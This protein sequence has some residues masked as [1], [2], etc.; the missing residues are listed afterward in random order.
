MNNLILF[1]LKTVLHFIARGNFLKIIEK[2]YGLIGRIT[3]YFLK[4]YFMYKIILKNFHE[5]Y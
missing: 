5:A 4:V 3:L 1:F 2:A